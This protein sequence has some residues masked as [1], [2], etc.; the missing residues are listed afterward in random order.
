[1]IAEIKGKITATGSNLSQRS[2]DNFTGNFFG[3]LKYVCI[4]S[5]LKPIL[6]IVKFRE[7]VNFN[8]ILLKNPNYIFW[9]KYNEYGEI[10]LIIETENAVIGIEVK[11]LSGISS[12]DDSI[13]IKANQNQLNKYSKLLDLHFK[14]KIKILILFAPNAIG[15]PIYQKILKLN[16]CQEVNVGFISWENIFNLLENITDKSNSKFENEILSDLLEYLKIKGFD[17]FK[18]FE[19]N[20][21]IKNH[22][23]FRYT[24]IFKIN[25][26]ITS[27]I[28]RKYFNYG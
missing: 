10:D 15:L 24:H 11:Y 13:D 19:S 12:D 6:N 5:G 20:K 14:E 21:N 16:L 26:E 8:E 18:K 22:Y 28:N 3:H 27:N 7:K 2:E 1:M 23:Y 9:K 25:W 17:K 4:E